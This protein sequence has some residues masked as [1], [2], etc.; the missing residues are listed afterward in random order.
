MVDRIPRKFVKERLGDGCFQA[1]IIVIPNTDVMPKGSSV[2]S[3][4]HSI[5]RIT[6]GDEK[7]ASL[8][9]M[10]LKEFLKVREPFDES[11]PNDGQVIQILSL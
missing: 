8:V 3:N 9:E 1:L 6:E 5:P 7:G 11:H 10:G 4:I 2:G